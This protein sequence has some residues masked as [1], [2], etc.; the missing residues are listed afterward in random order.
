M[1]LPKYASSSNRAG[2]AIDTLR[3]M[4][5]CWIRSLIDYSRE[6]SSAGFRIDLNGVR[7]L[8]GIEAFLVIRG[9]PT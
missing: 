1:V 5:N 8:S 2:L 3:T 6:K 7:A 9:T 4:G